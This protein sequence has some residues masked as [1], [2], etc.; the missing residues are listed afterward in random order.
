M[1]IISVYAMLFPA[2]GEMDLR[3]H[4]D[5]TKVTV[6]FRSFDNVAQNRQY[7]EN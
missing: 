7:K 4:T 2:D 5:K 3:T 1:K 6:T